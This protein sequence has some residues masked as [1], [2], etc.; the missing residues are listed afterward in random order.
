MH[1]TIVSEVSFH[2]MEASLVALRGFSI[3]LIV[4]N[5]VRFHLGFTNRLGD[6]DLKEGAVLYIQQLPGRRSL[7]DS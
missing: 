7:D 3:T 5:A 6:F 2:L 1:A 4:D